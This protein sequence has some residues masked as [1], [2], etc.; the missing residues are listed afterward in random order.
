MDIVFKEPDG[1]ADG[2]YADFFVG[3]NPS[4]GAFGITPVVAGV[5]LFVLRVDASDAALV[6]EVDDA[7]GG[8][9]DYGDGAEWN[10]AAQA[11]IDSIEF[12]P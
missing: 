9:S 10:A 6:I 4:H 12:A 1:C 7:K 5:R 11:F 2:D 3:V 8:G